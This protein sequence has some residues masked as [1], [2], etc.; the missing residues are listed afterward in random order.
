M[1]HQPAIVEP[2]GERTDAQLGEDPF[3]DSRH[4]GVVTDRQVVS[5]DHVDVALHELPKAAA[6]RRLAPIDPLDL[7]PPERKHE[8]VLMFGHVA[9]ERHGEV[10]AQRELWVPA[11]LERPG[12]LHEVHLAFRFTTRLGEKHVGQLDDRRL[13][14]HEAEPRIHGSDGVHHALEHHLLGRQQLQHTGH[15]SRGHHYSASAG[16]GCGEGSEEVRPR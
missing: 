14:R 10:V 7:I 6:L 4:L 1:P 8:V 13:D 15:R 5:A 9:G 16:I 11:L 3:D 2:D 12:G